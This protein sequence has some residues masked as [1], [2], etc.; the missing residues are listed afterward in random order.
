MKRGLWI[1]LPIA[2]AGF[3]LAAGDRGALADLWAVPAPLLWRAVL[4]PPL[5]AAAGAAAAWLLRRGTGG[6][7]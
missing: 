7:A 5:C 1:L 6:A 4:V 2:A 3:W